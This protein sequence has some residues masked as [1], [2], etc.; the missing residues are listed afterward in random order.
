MEEVC[1]KECIVNERSIICAPQRG[2]IKD[3]QTPLVNSTP[4]PHQQHPS[5]SVLLLKA[6][7]EEEKSLR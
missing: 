4:R 1:T 5:T 7:K 2:P 3:L 6:E